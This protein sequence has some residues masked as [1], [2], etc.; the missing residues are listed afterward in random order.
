MKSIFVLFMSL[1]MVALAANAYAAEDFYYAKENE[2]LY[3]TWVNMEYQDKPLRFP[4][5]VIKD[6]GTELFTSAN[7]NKPRYKTKSLI[8][9]RWDDADGN[10]MYKC[11]WVGDWGEV[12]STLYRVSNSGNT[13][14]Y[15]S[16]Y[17]NY[18][19]VIDTNLGIYRKYNRK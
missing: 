15:V 7:S 13:L 17:D 6:G 10:T 16:G 18:P 2:I 11:R 3:G 1:I 4:L 5:I 9:G 19:K 14:E 12:G 8:T